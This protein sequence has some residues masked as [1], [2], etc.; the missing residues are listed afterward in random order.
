MKRLWSMALALT[1]AAL[2][3]GCN[4]RS[5]VA[6]NDAEA[7]AAPQFSAKKGLLLPEQTRQSLGL[8]LVE[9]IERKLSSRL[10]LQLRVYQSDG[11]VARASSM[12][13]P[14]EAK[15]MKAG[16]AV[17]VR[18]KDSRTLPGRLTSV[19]DQLQRAT[20]SA[21]ALVEIPN[22][23]DGIT[24]GQFVQATV[25][26]ESGAAVVTIPRTALLGCSEGHFVYTVSGEHLVRTAV[27]VG[28]SNTEFV[29]IVDGLYAGDQVVSKPVMSLWMTELAAVK[30]GQACCVEPPKG[31]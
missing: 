8:K 20:G 28:A 18:L 31:K 7:T 29:E 9:V 24:V 22:A 11:A 21:E 23:P 27:K 30:G 26:I 14:D 6:A 4:S 2:M 1:G 16:Q 17:V 15:L 5:T 12:V 19:S 10:D 13:T 3:T 25:T